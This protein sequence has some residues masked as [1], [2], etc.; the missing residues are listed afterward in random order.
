MFLSIIPPPRNCHPAESL[1]LFQAE[2]DGYGCFD[3]CYVCY[4]YEFYS[5]ILLLDGICQQ[6]TLCALLPLVSLPGTAEASCSTV[7]LNVNTFNT[8]M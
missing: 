3:K 8:D 7:P 4:A 1:S 6:L 5:N 2:F